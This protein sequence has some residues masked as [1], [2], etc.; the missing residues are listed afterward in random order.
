ME[1]RPDMPLSQC[2]N[3]TVRNVNVNCKTFF[4][5]G[6]SD[7]YRLKDFVFENLNYPDS[8]GGIDK[9]MIENCDVKEERIVKSEDLICLMHCKQI[10][11]SSLT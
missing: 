6:T 9:S 2:N 7:K 11:H 8:A 1:N 4:D 10:F 3:V 5:V